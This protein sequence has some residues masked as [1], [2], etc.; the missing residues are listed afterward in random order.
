[1]QTRPRKSNPIREC[2]ADASVFDASVVQCSSAASG[3]TGRLPPGKQFP[4][5]LDGHR[6]IDGLERAISLMD[7]RSQRLTE[8]P[9]TFDGTAGD[10]GPVIGAS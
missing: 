6:S 10:L 9:G 4:F 7:I 1:M 5:A 2:R 8:T 3:W